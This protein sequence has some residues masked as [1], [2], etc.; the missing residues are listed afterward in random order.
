[1]LRA[2]VRFISPARPYAYLVTSDG[3]DAQVLC[4]KTAKLCERLQSSPNK[5]QLTVWITEPGSFY[6]T[7][8]VAANEQTT[9]LVLVE[10]QNRIYSGARALSLGATFAMIMVA[11]FSWRKHLLKLISRPKAV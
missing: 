5:L 4:D 2:L 1:M 7:W 8:L 11:L 9:P 6:G 10:M 3:Q